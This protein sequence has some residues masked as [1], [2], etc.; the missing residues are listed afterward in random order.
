MVGTMAQK[1]IWKTVERPGWYGENR[2]EKLAEYDE[3]YGSE[4]WRIRHRLGPYILDFKKSVGLYEMC[5]ERDFMHPDRKYLWRHLIHKASDVWTELE[6]DIDSK[7]DYSIQKAPAVHYEDIAIRRIFQ[8]YNVKFK[9]D[10]LIRI[11]A[12]SEDLAGIAL[13]SVHIPFVYP[14]YIEAPV[15]NKFPWWDRHKGSLECFWHLNKVLQ[16]R[17]Q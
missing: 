12:D 9:G 6:S 16:V 3:K 13:S 8:K 5:Y 1:N 7:T 17:K 2:V 4:N 10:E 14:E 11:R 15:N